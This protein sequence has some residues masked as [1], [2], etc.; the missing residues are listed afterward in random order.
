[1]KETSL[2]ED[3]IAV[4][5]NDVNRA[6]QFLPFDALKGLTEELESRIEKR[7][8]VQRIELSEDI[9]EEMSLTLRK[10]EKGTRVRINFYSIGHYYDIEGD[11]TKIDVIYHYLIIGQ[12]KIFFDDIFEIQIIG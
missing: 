2:L 12:Q 7:S 11:V 8:R 10:I 9:K 4:R 1:M 3:I 6:A 5:N